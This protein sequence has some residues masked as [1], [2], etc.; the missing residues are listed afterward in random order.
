MTKR[1]LALSVAVA[2][3]IFLGLLAILRPRSDKD[4]ESTAYT[5][6]RMDL[7]VSVLEGGNVSSTGSVEI[8]SQ[9][10][11]QATIIGIVPDGTIITE[12][13]VESGKVLVELDSSNLREKAA[14]QEITFQ[15]AQA[16][17]AQARESYE[18]Q[19]NQNE[20]NIKGGEL[21]VKFSRMD[22]EKY[23]G[24]DLAAGVLKGAFD[25]A[26]LTSGNP[27]GED[28]SD[29]FQ[30]LPFGGSAMQQWRKLKADIDLAGEEVTRAETEY[31]WSKQLA[32][33]KFI[34]GTELDADRL[35]L[36]RRK[37]ELE[38]AKLA[39]ELFLRYELPKEAEKLLSDYIEAGRELDRIKAKARSEL[40]KADS[41]LKSREATYRL[42]KDRL[43]KLT[44]Q[45]DQCTIRAPRPGM[46]VY[47]STADWRGRVSNPIEEGATVRERQVIITIPDPASM[48]VTVKVHESAV[49]MVKPGLKARIVL[50][51]FPDEVLWGHVQKVA[52]LPDA[53][54]PWLSPD[55]KVYSTS[56]SIDDPPLFLKTGMSAQVEIIVATLRDVMAVPIQAV[57][58]YEGRRVCYVLKDG[59]TERRFVT[60]AQ[61]NNNFIQ[62]VE[63]LSIGEQVLL[64]RPE[65]VVAAADKAA[66][67]EGSAPAAQGQADSG[68]PKEE[69]ASQAAPAGG[70]EKVRE[71][72]AVD[73][74]MN[75]GQRLAPD[76][77]EEVRKRW[78][79][80]SPEEREA[81]RRRFRD[82]RG[83]RQ[84]P[85]QGGGSR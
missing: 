77:Q 62:I 54:N 13:D 69:M 20:S 29:I 78:E 81:M 9:V 5:V 49:D 64:H 6:R 53:Q 80:M 42:Q 8:K 46:V 79:A 10:E 82:G 21:N 35:A 68:T 48:A 65:T 39:L 55:L 61:F 44:Q 51:A 25:L 31:G 58:A 73:A 19:K 52:V 50:D 74:D 75:D 57:S 85:R 12:E 14:Q 72:P 23:L 56:V 32:E 36:Q 11:G 16:T 83:D 41:E 67:V 30:K 2:L 38:Q 84:S 70:S 18:I 76:R 45:I 71:E 63:G 66:S 60:T 28:V 22:L 34:T 26:V 47:A 59:R 24:A 1:M 17:Y 3:L 37:V 40:A 4:A 15:N 33:K 27:D 7:V 43:E